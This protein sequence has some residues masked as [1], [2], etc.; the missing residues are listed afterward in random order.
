LLDRKLLKPLRGTLR[1]HPRPIERPRCK[2]RQ[3]LRARAREHRLAPNWTG[4]VEYLH[5][6]FGGSETL[7]GVS[8]GK[9]DVETIKAGINYKF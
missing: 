9:F 3:D 4:K 2:D 1:K 6:G 5:Y 8:V 7:F